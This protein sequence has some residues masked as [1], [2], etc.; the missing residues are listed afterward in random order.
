MQN[1]GGKQ[2]VRIERAASLLSLN[3]VYPSAA[4]VAKALG[5][6]PQKYRGDGLNASENKYRR[7]V[8]AKLG[9]DLKVGR[10]V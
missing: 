10:N 5:R 4:S 9:I 1:V 2:R 3:G 6:T 7:L 8:M